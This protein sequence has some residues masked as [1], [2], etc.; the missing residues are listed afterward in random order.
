MVGV[1]LGGE[2]GRALPA[3]LAAMRPGSRL[4]LLTLARWAD[5]RLQQYQM[6]GDEPQARGPI[7]VLLDERIVIGRPSTWAAAVALASLSTAARERRACTV[8][9]F[10]S[11]IRYVVRLDAQG[12]GWRHD[13]RDHSSAERMGGAAD[14]ALHVATSSP[15][16]GTS[17]DSAPA[18]RPGPGGR[19]AVHV[20]RPAAGDRRARQVQRRR[21]GAAGPGP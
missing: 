5:K 18:L 11:G 2:L 7:V 15:S 6:Q 4:R 9:G 13:R 14:V 20:C 19:R 8:V 16:G 17:F 3:E 10:N 21:A 12:R 1:E